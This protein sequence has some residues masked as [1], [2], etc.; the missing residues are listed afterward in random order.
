MSDG[1]AAAG[2]ASHRIAALAAQRLV[3]VL[4]LVVVRFDGRRVGH[5]QMEQVKAA[6]ASAL[7]QARSRRHVEQGC[8]HRVRTCP[9]ASSASTSAAPRAAPAVSTAS[10]LEEALGDGVAQFLEEQ[11]LEAVDVESA[12]GKAR[13]YHRRRSRG[14]LNKRD[15]QLARRRERGEG[16]QRGRRRRR[17]V[18]RPATAAAAA[19]AASSSP[20]VFLSGCNLCEVHGSPVQHHAK[21]AVK[22]APRNRHGGE[23]SSPARTLRCRRR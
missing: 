1:S 13:R 15:V 21:E 5:G 14:V 11:R 6:S 17:R 8:L 18:M 2:V 10:A 16:R 7:R 20:A 12:R 22:A 9:P 23:G 3:L 19:A 4:V